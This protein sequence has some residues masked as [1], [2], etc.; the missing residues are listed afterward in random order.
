MERGKVPAR[1]ASKVPPVCILFGRKA[2]ED[3]FDEYLAREHIDRIKSLLN[4]PESPAVCEY[5]AG[6][7]DIADVLDEVSTPSMWGGARL[8]ILRGAEA[9]L[10]PPASGREGLEALVERMRGFAASASPPGRLVLVARALKAERG[11]PKTAFKPAAALISEVE[12]GGGLFSCMPPFENALKRALVRK[13]SA[14]ARK[15]SDAAAQALVE[16]VGRDQLALMAELEKLI[17]ATAEGEIIRPQHVEELAARRPQASVF[18]LADS[19]M[20]G[21][22]KAALRQLDELRSTPATRALG[23]LIGGL[24][25]SF[26]RYMDAARLAAAGETPVRA[27][28]SAGVP[29]FVQ[30]DFVRR[31]A[32]W[33]PRE[34]SALLERL[35]RCDVEVKTGSVAEETALVT[36]VSDACARRFQHG[37]IAG[38]WI[39][40]V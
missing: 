24:A 8:V 20:E 26:R 16:I 17:V 15:L 23:M 32:G 38:R 29:R 22:A 11:R 13:A 2:R 39:Y 9:V 7:A 19:I 1:T 28:A 14:S 4:L 25:S 27:A 12:A 6:Q 37:E 18:S 21:D 3:L 35:L 34:L 36:F 33:T 10:D 5:E 40:E 31:L 30:R